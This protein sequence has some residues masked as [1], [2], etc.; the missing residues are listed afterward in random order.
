M[1]CRE[2]LTERKKRTMALRKSH[3][4][5]KVKTIFTI[6]FEGVRAVINDIVFLFTSRN[7]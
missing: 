1:K 7:E 3:F 6:H 2:K 4:G 5:I